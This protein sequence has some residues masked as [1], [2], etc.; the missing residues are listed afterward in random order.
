MSGST[1]YPTETLGGLITSQSYPPFIVP[2]D[3]NPH[4]T[5]REPQLAELEE[6]F[7][8]R[9]Q[10]TKMAITGLGGVGKT[11]LLLEFVYRVRDTYQ[12]CSIIWIPATNMESLEQAYL[13]VAQQLG[14]P[15]W[16]E[17][18][19]NV[20]RLV[21]NYLSKD[22]A[23]KWL[24][25]FDN[26][27]DI[28]MWT[29]NPSRNGEPGQLIGYLPRNECGCVSFTT[30]D[31]KTA[32]KLTNTNIIEVSEMDE[33]VTAQLLQRSLT[34]PNLVKNQPDREARLEELTYLPL[35]IIQAA[36]YINENGIA[37]I[38]CL[39][40]LAEQEEDV[41]DPSQ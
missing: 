15:R 35:A 7:S 14:I 36:A 38:D 21:Q 30:R 17:D 3:R 33:D 1:R 22:S 34:D 28:D 18:K 10:T 8:E 2:F 32:V 26:A 13:G 39:S 12:N 40:L 24:L 23:G 16:A 11:Q 25:V 19:A 5:G 20:K 29:A 27:D 41:I 6:K 9:G 4:F 31:R 37:F